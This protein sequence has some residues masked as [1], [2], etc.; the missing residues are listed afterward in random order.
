VE[1][2]RAA[3]GRPVMLD[4]TLFKIASFRRGNL[5]LALVNVG[6]LGLLFVLPL[7]LVGVHGISPVQISVAILPLA[8]GAF[9]GGGC[10]GRLANRHGAHRVVRLGMVLKVTAVAALALTLTATTTGFGLAPWMLVYGI[11]LGLT[12]AQLTNVSLADVPRARAGQASGTQSTSRQVGAALGIAFIGTVFA[13]SLGHA[14]AGRLEGGPLPPARQAAITHELRESAG[15]YARDLH[16]TPGMAAVAEAADQSLAV[17][18]RRAALATAAVLALGLVMSLRLRPG[19]R[20]CRG[21][22]PLGHGRPR[23]TGDRDRR[24][25]NG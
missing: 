3:A 17:A 22:S 1:Q 8:A 25:S 15:T 9:L 18:T 13:T 19:G 4:L 24:E 5:A 16:A 20:G 10:A 23:A 11:G 7:F 21:S 6:E 12:S 14:M 2:A